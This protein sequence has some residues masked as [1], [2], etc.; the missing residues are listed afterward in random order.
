MQTPELWIRGLGAYLP[1]TR[2][3]VESAIDQGLTTAEEAAVHDMAGAA[4]AGDLPAPEMALRS[5]REAFERSGADPDDVRLLLYTDTWH[6]GPDG[7]FPQY[8]LQHHLVRGHV[9]AAEVRQ[10]CN[11]LFTAMELAAPHLRDA[12]ED[13]TALLV[14]ADNFG[15]PNID[16]W[17]SG[18]FVM[19]D[20]AC[21][22]L[23]GRAPGPVRVLAVGSMVVPELELYHRSGEPEFPPAATTGR[24]L[25]FKARASD[26]ADRH[27]ADPSVYTS[28]FTLQKTMVA[29]VER[30]LD[31]A[32]VG[33]G[34][35]TRAAFGNLGP[36]AVEHRWMRVLGLPMERSTWDHGRTVGHVGAADPF[37]GLHHLLETGAV[38]PGDHVILG[39][40]GSG[41]TASC[42]VVRVDGP[43]PGV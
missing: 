20:G 41:M 32:G 34:D 5:A 12:P 9:L 16:R 22:V 7:W 13:A 33:Y 1:D 29:L 24:F 15:T 36:E 21:S 35:I 18:A 17:R 42:A 38:A 25:D 19:G 11:A 8:H 39:G 4:V 28:W 3:S 23:L 31:E 43:W 40:I 37:L 27:V 14:A 10:G 6:Q 2:V 26:H 30:T